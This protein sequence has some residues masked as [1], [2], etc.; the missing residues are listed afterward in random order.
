LY[1]LLTDSDVP[2]YLPWAEYPEVKVDPWI[3]W[4]PA[5]FRN[6]I[7]S[8]LHGTFSANLNQ[9]LLVAITELESAAYDWADYQAS[10]YSLSELSSLKLKYHQT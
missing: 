7:Y 5:V 10:H 8:S 3:V 9:T 6:A 2:D 1:S 4:S